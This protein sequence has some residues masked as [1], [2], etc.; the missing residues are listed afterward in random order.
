MNESL[1]E[2]RL[3]P[4]RESYHC[5]TEL[6]FLRLR[7][8]ELENS[9]GCLRLLDIGLP[10]LKQTDLKLGPWDFYYYLPRHLS[11]PISLLKKLPITL[12]LMHDEIVFDAHWPATLYS[13]AL[14][15]LAQ[16]ISLPKVKLGED[17]NIILNMLSS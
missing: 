10:V 4:S 2:I 5:Y 1:Q 14:E 9:M 17:G 11:S 3:Q 6:D 7:T 15:P 13:R 12:N 8:L 16:L